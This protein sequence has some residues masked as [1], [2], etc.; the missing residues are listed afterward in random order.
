MKLLLDQNLSHRLLSLLDDFFPASVHVR[1]L[2]LAEAD[3]LTIWNYA[4]EHGLV[5]VTQDSDYADWNKLRGAP[6][7]IIWLRC[8]NASVNDILLKLRNAVDRIEL[9]DSP[10]AEVEI[11]EIW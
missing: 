3:D 2:G 8:G 5:I 4:K 1:A 6:P 10:T 7:K 9:L 11:I